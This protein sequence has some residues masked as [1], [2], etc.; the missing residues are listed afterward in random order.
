MA[1]D[2][3]PGTLFP[4][5]VMIRAAPPW[6]KYT[7][8]TMPLVLT[9][10]DCPTI[11]EP[12]VHICANA[13]PGTI[14]DVMPATS[15]VVNLLFITHLPF[16]NARQLKDAKPKF[17]ATIPVTVNSRNGFTFDYAV[18]IPIRR[19]AHTIPCAQLASASSLK[20]GISTSNV[21]PLSSTMWNSPAIAPDEVSSGQPE[22]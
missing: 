1:T 4:A 14:I 5:G 17:F 11:S 13:T 7:V 16:I 22:T 15:T 10:I 8:L 20:A 6:S 18:K 3:R 21:E 12:G 9:W 19:D 2:Q